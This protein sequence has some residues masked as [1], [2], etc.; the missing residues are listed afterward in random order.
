M[1]NKGSH[2]PVKSM[3]AGVYHVIRWILGIIFIYAS[4]DK[5]LH[6]QAFAL[7]VYNYQLLPEELINLTALIL[8]WLELL[9]GVCLI[10]HRLIQGTI[11]IS[12]ILLFT[13]TI[14]VFYNVHRGLDINCGCFSTD[15]KKDPATMLTIVRDVIF[16]IMSFYLY[17]FAFKIKK[18]HNR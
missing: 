13:F 12:N 18:A 6:P 9:L 1:G 8:P 11:I 7:V 14:I 17:L 4:Y 10:T 15:I 16:L 3:Q 2:Q 5:I